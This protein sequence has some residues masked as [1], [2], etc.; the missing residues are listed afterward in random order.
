MK[1]VQ[2]YYP[3]KGPH[4]IIMK[5]PSA[6]ITNNELRMYAYEESDFLIVST[7]MS[8]QE[9]VEDCIETC[10]P[11][12]VMHTNS[13]YPAK[14]EELN[15]EYI[16]YLQHNTDE[17]YIGYSSHDIGNDMSLCAV[18][19]GATWIE[20][21]ITLDQS[22]W[23]SDQSSSSEPD[24]I[25]NLVKSIHRFGL[26]SGTYGPRCVTVSEYAKIKT[27]RG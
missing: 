15:L 7:G 22:L 18:A 11:N 8:T 20:K 9:E 12:V 27:L 6:L 13:S 5:I 3:S 10:N 21:H 2:C 4:G 26:A 19:L 25:F 14:I 17:I 23:G 1:H 16:Q 24:D